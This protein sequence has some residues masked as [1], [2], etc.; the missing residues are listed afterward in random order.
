MTKNIQ[1][2]I[3][4]LD[5]T[6]NINNETFVI[7]IDN[8]IIASQSSL[9]AF[10]EDIHCLQRLGVS[11]VIV[12]DGDKSLDEAYNE[13]NIDCHLPDNIQIA[14]MLLTGF[15][16]KNIVSQINKAGSLAVNISGKDAK[17]IEATKIRK[18]HINKNSNVQHLIHDC[19]QGIAESVNPHI[20]IALE[21]RNIIPVISP[22]AEVKGRSVQLEG[23]HTAATI[24]AFLAADRFI[25]MSYHD[26][27]KKLPHKKTQYEEL[28]FTKTKKNTPLHSL[29]EKCKIVF[30]SNTQEVIVIKNQKPH[31]LL[32]SIIEENND[33][34]IINNDNQGDKYA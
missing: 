25:I 29:I 5:K 3:E 8:E 28:L 20:L 30:E 32:H 4:L 6:E 1:T 27:Y 21:N 12:H 10:A 24:C 23:L 31:S 16:N 33:N 34:L 14:E 26:D 19:D 22:L 2:L 17:L 9:K 13:L 11:I 7:Y 15:I 18:V